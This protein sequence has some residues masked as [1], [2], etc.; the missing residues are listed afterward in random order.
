MLSILVMFVPCGLMPLGP[1]CLLVGPTVRGGVILLTSSQCAA[2]TYS[3]LLLLPPPFTG[4]QP[5]GCV[6]PTEGELADSESAASFTAPAVSV[7]SSTSDFGGYFTSDVYSHL[8]RPS[9][10]SGPSSVVSGHPSLLTG[11]L[12]GCSPLLPLQ[13]TRT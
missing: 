13:L 10:T 4:E 1:N 9:R 7:V 2:G 8:S 12:L 5:S 6:P 3:L 11:Q